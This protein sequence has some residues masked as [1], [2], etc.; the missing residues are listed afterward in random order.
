MSSSS[1][2]SSSKGGISV[3]QNTLLQESGTT[4]GDALPDCVQ[5]QRECTGKMP[6]KD[7]LAKFRKEFETNP[8][9]AFQLVANQKGLKSKIREFCI[10]FV[11]EKR[12]EM[13]E[14]KKDLVRQYKSMKK[15]SKELSSS[16][17]KSD[18]ENTLGKFKRNPQKAFRT[19][20][21]AEVSAIKKKD[22]KKIRT[23]CKEWLEGERK[24]M[25]ENEKRLSGLYKSWRINSKRK[26]KREDSETQQT[27][28]EKKFKTDMA[29]RR[30]NRIRYVTSVLTYT[31]PGGS[32]KYAD[33][34][35]SVILRDNFESLKEY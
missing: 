13:D 34:S 28:W 16:T 6:A 1:R 2:L 32:S 24:K 3:S 25:G 7:I 9:H 33:N 29:P 31:K 18:M 17:T 10:R 35:N 27:G 30:G 19:L 23:N 22:R 12:A 11:E 5:G 14:K 4:T 20:T 15:R 21:D 8:E 26:R